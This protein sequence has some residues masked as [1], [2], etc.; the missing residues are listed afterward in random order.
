MN[1]QNT[2]IHV[3]TIKREPILIFALASKQPLHKRYFIIN[4]DNKNIHKYFC[5]EKIS[6]K[7]LIIYRFFIW[8]FY[9]G[10]VLKRK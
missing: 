9:I 6:S 2:K 1:I 7:S 5:I 10:I 3:F 8:S 4:T